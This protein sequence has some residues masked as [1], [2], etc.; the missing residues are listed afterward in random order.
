MVNLSKSGRDLW[1]RLGGKP[2]SYAWDTKIE[3]LGACYDCNCGAAVLDERRSRILTWGG[4]GDLPIADLQVYR[5]TDLESDVLQVGGTGP[6]GRTVPSMTIDTNRDVLYVFGGWAAGSRGPSRDM[7]R[8]ELAK[9]PLSWEHVAP[10]SPW[11]RG[12]NGSGIIYDHRQDRL[13]LFGGDAGRGKHSFTPLN[14][15]WQFD[16]SESR[17]WRL[18][19]CGDLPPA[20]WHLMM[21]LDEDSRVVYMF[22]GA[23]IGPDGLD[24]QLYALHLDSNTW[25]RIDVKGDVPPSLQGGTLTFDKQRRVLVLCGG[26]RHRGPKDATMSTVWVFDPRERTW[27][28][29]CEAPCLQ[30]RDHVAVYDPRTEAHYVL[31]GKVTPDVGNWYSSGEEIRSTARI[32]LTKRLEENVL[33]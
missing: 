12:R 4:G 14:D 17:W 13:L 20:R 23:G 30:R 26:L 15:L 33:E 1:V 10:K 2:G 32:Q 11:P 3:L 28:H 7:F 5:L 21:A 8:L 25:Q 29:T 6:R 27:W 19:N 16:L 31:G 22:G 9:E 24:R 18:K